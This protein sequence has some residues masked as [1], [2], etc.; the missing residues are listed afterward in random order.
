[1]TVLYCS[2]DECVMLNLNLITNTNLVRGANRGLS[3]IVP[4]VSVCNLNLIINTNL[5]R[6]FN[7]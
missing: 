1:M 5:V 3:S 6:R 2:H 7:R 4:M